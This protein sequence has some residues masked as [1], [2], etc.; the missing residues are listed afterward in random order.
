L[1]EVSIKY[2]AYAMAKAFW[3]R[4]PKK[5]WQNIKKCKKSWLPSSIEGR[6]TG[7]EAVVVM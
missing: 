1:S 7:N 5:F 6:E 4:S 3:N 2:K